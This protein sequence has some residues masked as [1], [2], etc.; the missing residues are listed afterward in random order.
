MDQPTN[1]PLHRSQDAT[2]RLLAAKQAMAA[3]CDAL[4]HHLVRVNGRMFVCIAH[5]CKQGTCT[6]ANNG[7]PSWLWGRA[8]RAGL[9]PLRHACLG[10]GAPQLHHHLTCPLQLSTKQLSPQDCVTRGDSCGGGDLGGD[11]AAAT[12][13]GA[14]DA[15]DF[16]ARVMQA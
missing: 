12:G 4:E 14:L 5:P 6:L 10:R 7:W 9:Q 16:R 1:P 15:D 13:N 3:A 11:A 2:A 8:A